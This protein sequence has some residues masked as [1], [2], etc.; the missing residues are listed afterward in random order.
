MQPYRIQG[1]TLIEV[2]VVIVLVGLIV[3]YVAPQM[4]GRADEAKRQAAELQLQQVSNAIEVFQFE[5]GRYPKTLSELIRKPEQ[6]TGWQGPYLKQA[7]QLQDPWQRELVYRYPGEHGTFDLFSLGADGQP[8][9]DGEAADI[10]NW[11]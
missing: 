3:S 11:H 7:R 1:F 6:T 8:Q 5:V 9:G 10:T 4:L 2:I